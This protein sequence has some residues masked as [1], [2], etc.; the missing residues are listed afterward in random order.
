MSEEYEGVLLASAKNPPYVDVM[1]CQRSF[2]FV[3]H[4]EEKER[5]IIRDSKSS[6]HGCRK[7]STNT[8]LV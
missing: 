2:H 7:T 6:K 1:E 8:Y 3:W 5:K 4:E